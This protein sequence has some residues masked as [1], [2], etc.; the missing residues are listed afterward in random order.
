MERRA[1]KKKS[2]YVEKTLEWLEKV[3]DRSV[4]YRD[5]DPFHQVFQ[6]TEHVY[7]IFEE[8]ANGGSDLWI[9]LIE[10]E[11]AALLVDTGYGIGDLAALVRHLIGDKKLYVVN[12]HE[13]YD[14]VLGNCRFD[15]VYCHPYALPF[16]TKNYMSQ[17]MFSPY[18]DENGNGIYLDFNKND[19]PEF[20]GYE[21][22]SCNDGDRFEL[23]VDHFVDVIYTPGHAAG[24]LSFLDRKNKILF[25][26]A[27][28]SG[29]TLIEGLQEQYREYN[30]V[31]AFA[32]ALEKIKE[33]ELDSFDWIYAAHEIPVLEKGY[34]L[35]Q[36]EVC[37]DLIKD[38]TCCENITYD[39]N[40]R[41]C[42]CHMVGNAGLRYFQ[43]SFK[44]K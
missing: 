36:L 6:F 30:T 39:E 20:Q 5:I 43:T 21:L 17:D 35:E 29:N 34:L 13:H 9:N 33:K 37:K 15:R 2:P 31:E 16:I 26:G 7:S 44:T 27:M 8:C 18:M 11:S 24:G 14:H 1:I 25:T 42:Y 38:H 3:S 4:L 19:L 22:V 12:T 28:H 23:G 41:E 40:G 32:E 10:G